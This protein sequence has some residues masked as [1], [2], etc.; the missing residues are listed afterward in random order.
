LVV[1]DVAEWKGGYNLNVVCLEVM[2]E[3]FGHDED[4][5]QELLYLWVLYL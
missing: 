1:E 3:F 2:L 5:I 4:R